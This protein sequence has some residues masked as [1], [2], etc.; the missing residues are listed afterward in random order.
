MNLTQ[1][2]LEYFV[3]NTE[4]LTAEYTMVDKNKKSIFGY[5]K[6]FESKNF[7]LNFDKEMIVFIVSSRVLRRLY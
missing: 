3:M 5:D 2:Q 7:S 6:S 1:K 4:P